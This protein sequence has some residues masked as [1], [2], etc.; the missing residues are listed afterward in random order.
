MEFNK[1]CSHLPSIVERSSVVGLKE[2]FTKGSAVPEPPFLVLNHAKMG[3]DY[4]IRKIEDPLFYPEIM[5]NHES[6]GLEFL[7]PKVDS[8]LALPDTKVFGFKVFPGFDDQY[9]VHQ[10]HLQTKPDSDEFL[11]IKED[12][13]G[14]NLSNIETIEQMALRKL[15]E[16]LETPNFEF[17]A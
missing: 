10:I 16:G 4:F 7:A 13:E 6:I 9:G 12:S 3:G 1:L 15:E 2:A 11:L 14:G 17:F 5:N 8:L